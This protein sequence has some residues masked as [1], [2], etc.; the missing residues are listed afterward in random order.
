MYKNIDDKK[1][2]E[3]VEL[4]RGGN[5]EA[6][7]ELV[8][9][10]KTKG[11]AL[12]RSYYV[13]GH[14]QE[15]LENECRIALCK[16]IDTYDYNREGKAAFKTY[17]EVVMR[18]HLGMLVRRVSVLLESKKKVCDLDFV[19]NVSLGT[20]DTCEKVC[21]K[22]YLDYI[23]NYIIGNDVE[24]L[25]IFDAIIGKVTYE[26]LKKSGRCTGNVY[27]KG[28]KL[29]ARIRSKIDEDDLRD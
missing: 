5:P 28:S 16:A 13:F 1:D 14:G 22:E 20:S 2:E 26:E 15:D 27:Y 8:K 19:L 10:F 24:D 23:K 7:V 17:V 29:I 25:L 11:S 21:S 6:F 12:A 3:L 18:N 9:R 4:A